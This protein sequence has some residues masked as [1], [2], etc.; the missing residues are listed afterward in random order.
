MTTL[1]EQLFLSDELEDVAA[2]IRR[3]HSGWFDFSLLVNKTCVDNFVDLSGRTIKQEELIVMTLFI[4]CLETFETIVMISQRGAQIQARMLLRN[5][6]DAL[7]PLVA[8]AYDESDSHWKEFADQEVKSRKKHATNYRLLPTAT[9]EGI[10]LSEEIEKEMEELIEEEKIT[11]INR[12]QWAERAGLVDWYRSKYSLLC[13]DTHSSVRSLEAHIDSDG[14]EFKGFQGGPNEDEIEST[15][16]T[17]IYAMLNAMKAQ[18][19]EFSLGKEDNI[20]EL[21]QM[22]NALVKTLVAAG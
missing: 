10:K 1:D 7:F 2:Q 4:R 18:N 17:S 16:A 22:L 20:N 13:D 5:L 14:D 21:E 19:K 11:N 12:Y 6:I 15:L 9:D 3:N 8:I